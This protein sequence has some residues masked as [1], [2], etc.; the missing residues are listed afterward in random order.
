MLAGSTGEGATL[1][2]DEKGRLWE[3]GVA[4]CGDAH[5]DRRHRH[6]RHPPHASS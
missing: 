4:E 2:D 5:G 1:T 3:L 6:L